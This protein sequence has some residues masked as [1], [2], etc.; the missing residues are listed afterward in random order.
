[1]HHH[2]GGVL[3]QADHYQAGRK[4]GF[5][6]RGVQVVRPNVAVTDRRLFWEM[7]CG[8]AT[9]DSAHSPRP[10]SSIGRD[11]LRFAEKLLC[12]TENDRVCDHHANQ[13]LLGSGLSILPGKTCAA[14][15]FRVRSFFFW[16]PGTEPRGG[17]LFFHA[18]RSPRPF[19]L[20]GAGH[21]FRI[22]D[23]SFDEIPLAF[24]YLNF[25]SC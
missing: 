6:G 2:E 8:Q 9:V 15:L 11:H 1:M 18:R 4:E 23:T 19:A 3:D 16:Q 21:Q 24:E 20:A 7:A 22:E 5:V 10:I 13:P 25:F 12:P 14:V 17:V